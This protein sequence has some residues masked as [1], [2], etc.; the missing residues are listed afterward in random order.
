MNAIASEIAPCL[1]IA[2]V[3]FL[4]EHLSGTLNF[5]CD[6]LS[7]LHKEGIEV[8]Q[9]AG[10]R[11]AHDA[12]GPSSKLLL[13]VFLMAVY[14]SDMHHDP[15]TQCMWAGRIQQTGGRDFAALGPA[16]RAAA[17]KGKGKEKGQSREPRPQEQQQRRSSTS[18]L[19]LYRNEELSD[20]SHTRDQH[21]RCRRRSRYTLYK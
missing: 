1:E 19:S 17:L 10:Q 14:M 2:G 11:P 3:Q 5:D 4:P 20:G 9:E 16:L 8:P 15:P 7:R 18:S 6:A 13:G 12:E 21:D